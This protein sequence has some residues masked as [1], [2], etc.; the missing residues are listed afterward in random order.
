MIREKEEMHRYLI[1]SFVSLLVCFSLACGK[2]VKGPAQEGKSNEE[3]I[4]E[5]FAVYKDGYTSKNIDKVMSVI[6]STYF[7][8]YNRSKEAYKS[9]LQSLWAGWEWT[10]PVEMNITGQIAI[11][12]GGGWIET[13]A[14]SEWRNSIADLNEVS[15]IWGVNSSS[16]V[17]MS[18]KA[19]LHFSW[20]LLGGYWY[21]TRIT[22]TSARVTT[23]P[24]SV[25]K[26]E[27]V[28]VNVFSLPEGAPLTAYNTKS[29]S[30]SDWNGDSIPLQNQGSGLYSGIFT[31]PSS[32]GEYALSATV[33]DTTTN[34]TISLQHTFTVQ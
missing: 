17:L 2:K 18:A 15:E 5:R 22:G 6:A 23:Q 20:E 16:N 10:R 1:L 19:N 24:A 27:Q 33:S 9:W 4:R 28:T 26:G 7:D 32:A 31:A 8:G 14:E 21:I 30:L 11:E 12:L 13:G 34:K 25:S 3:L 29:A